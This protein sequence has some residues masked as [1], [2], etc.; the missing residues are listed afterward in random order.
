M[1]KVTESYLLCKIDWTETQKITEGIYGGFI[2][3][4]FRLSLRRKE[5]FSNSFS[6]DL[7]SFR[8]KVTFFFLLMWLLKK[9]GVHW[10]VYPLGICSGNPYFRDSPLVSQSMCWDYDSL[11]LV[12]RNK[13]HQEWNIVYLGFIFVPW[14]FL[15]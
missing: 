15:N 4:C 9:C 11:S 3:L 13:L 2:W 1:R 10:Q 12:S 5:W 6:D 8:E 7:H 14:H